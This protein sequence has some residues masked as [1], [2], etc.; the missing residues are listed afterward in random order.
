MFF[1]TRPSYLPKVR[2]RFIRLIHWR[3]SVRAHGVVVSGKSILTKTSRT[4]FL[5]C[6]PLKKPYIYI[7]SRVF[8]LRRTFRQNV[9][10]FRTLY[11]PRGRFAGFQW[12]RLLE[13]HSP[14]PYSVP[15]VNSNVRRTR[16]TSCTGR[17]D[18]FHEKARKFRL[19]RS[20]DSVNDAAATRFVKTITART[21]FARFRQRRP[22]TPLK[23][24]FRCIQ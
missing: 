3:R 6:P 2:A 8:R 18:D 23:P 21:L 14:Y 20:L 4:H 1:H 19:G 7:Y 22:S 12:W 24:P 17:A 5:P 11:R 15:R 13:N 9:H 10:E 16:R